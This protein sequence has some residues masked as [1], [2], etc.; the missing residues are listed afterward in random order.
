MLQIGWPRFRPDIRDMTCSALCR[1]WRNHHSDARSSVFHRLPHEQG[2]TPTLRT[3]PRREVR[4]RKHFRPCLYSPFAS[5]TQQHA[6]QATSPRRHQRPQSTPGNQGG[7]THARHPKEVI[8][9]PGGLAAHPPTGC[10]SPH[11]LASTPRHVAAMPCE[12][13]FQAESGVP[14]WRENPKR[15]DTQPQVRVAHRAPQEV[16]W[17]TP[18]PYRLST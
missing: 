1:D 12:P 10:P 18:H 3:P 16:I 11:L 4:P 8:R 2:R 9:H 7:L 17:I 15:T 14:D 13:H 5:E 6:A